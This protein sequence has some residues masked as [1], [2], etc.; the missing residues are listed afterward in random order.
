MAGFPSG[1]AIRPT[2]KNGFVASFF[3]Q[4]LWRKQDCLS[5]AKMPQRARPRRGFVVACLL[6]FQSDTGS[7]RHFGLFAEAPPTSSLRPG[8]ERR[9]MASFSFGLDMIDGCADLSKT[10]IDP[11]IRVEGLFGRYRVDTRELKYFVDRD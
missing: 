3:F 8:G 11:R 7:Q 6:C 5:A 2:S 1:R 10:I 4:R 9:K